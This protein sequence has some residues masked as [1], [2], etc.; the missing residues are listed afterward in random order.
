M[1]LRFS[2][3]ALTALV[4]LAPLAHAQKLQP[5]LWELT[6]SNMQVGGQQLPDVDVMLEQLNAFA[7]D[8]KQ[9]VE[10]AL[11]K[12]GVTVAGKGLQVCLT[13]AQAQSEQIP[14]QDTQS[15]CSQQVTERGAQM[16][17]FR[18]S[19]PSA[20][21]IGEVHFVSDRE[22]QAK[23]SGTFKLNGAQQNGSTDSK[24]VWLGQSCGAVQ[25]RQS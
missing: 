2:P 4:L 8:Q 13:P 22:F 24:G 20:Q 16:W 9:R 23:I 14:M 25:P 18:F 10:Q 17:K 11:K 19:C 12:Q 5:G 15:G 1:R 21:G 7:P 3:I 6:S